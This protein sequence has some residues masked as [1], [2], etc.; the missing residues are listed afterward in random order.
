MHDT[1]FAGIWLSA[2]LRE[3]CRSEQRRRAWLPGR[4]RR[5]R[6]PLKAKVAAKTKS[7]AKTKSSARTT[8]RTK[9]PL[10]K[11][12]SK[13]ARQ[14]QDR[15]PQPCPGPRRRPRASQRRQ[16][17]HRPNRPSLCLD[18]TTPASSNPQA[19]A[20]SGFQVEGTNGNAPF[21]LKLHRGEGM[22]LV[23]M[24]WKNG[25]PP[26]DFVGFAIEYQEPG[27][28]QYY[29]LNNRLG[30]LDSGR[31]CRSC[32]PLDASIADPEIPMG[33]FPT[34]CRSRRRLQISRHA[35]VHGCAG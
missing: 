5:R 1:I 4:R 25:Q 6:S 34:Q 11:A 15:K 27:G 22:T 23:A 8:R 17:R 24:N 33:A 21:T 14:D 20:P 35:H 26:Q 18:P 28:S 32:H 16:P 31:Q 30:F 10:R 3:S 29:A 19:S 2:S 9:S 7:K 13:S 12:K